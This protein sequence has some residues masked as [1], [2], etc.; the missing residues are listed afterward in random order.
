MESCKFPPEEIVGA[1]NFKFAPK[2][3]Q[4]VLA[5]NFAFLD[6]NIP[7]KRR[8]SDNFPIAQNLVH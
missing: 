8:F 5:Q 2:F 6:E 3:S 7:T 4:S 1:Q